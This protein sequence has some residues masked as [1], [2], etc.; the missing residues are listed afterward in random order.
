[1]K[2]KKICVIG[3]GYV[4]LVSS[5]CFA[6]IGHKVICVDN[7]KE[8]IKKLQQNIVPIFE[9]GLKRLIVKNKKTGRLSFT[10]EILEGVKKS[11]IIFIAVH[12]PTD[13]NGQT[14]LCYVES[15][16]QEIAKSMDKYKLIVS[17]STMPVE[18]GKKIKK[19]I[20]NHSPRNIDFDVVSNPE[21]LREGSAVRDFLKPDRI[22]IG[23]EN[24]KA[25][26]IMREIYKPI[27]APIIITN[28]ET[29]EIIKHACNS[30]LATK[31]SFIN[32]IANIC[33]KVGVDVEE[34]AAAM[35]LDK[36][37]G[38]AFLRPGI[39][40]GGSCLPKDLDAFLYISAKNGYDFKLLEAVKN[41][42]RIQKENFVEK[43]KR[44][45]QN[46]KG[47]KLGVLGLAFKPDTDDIRNA[48]SVDII[49]ML[50]KEGAEIKVYDPVAVKKAKEV[51][52]EKITYCQ[53]PYEAALNA[54]ALIILTEWP[55][56]LKID[57]KKIKNLMK[58]P[59]IVDGRNIFIPEKM[60][61]LGFDYSC[62]SRGKKNYGKK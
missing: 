32:A 51:F 42:N 22:V 19:T 40:F 29:A 53:S 8:K 45:I 15:V 36:R 57:L 9:P 55:E 35:G 31:I 4:G 16:A 34:V 12:T 5:A 52:K 37:I 59:I 62:I 13:E 47:K 11:E 61:K 39:G 3:A 60:R 1:M 43:I 20:K 27:K 56:F 46:L 28:I 33:E 2:A 18:T 30:F 10:T 58:K 21:F 48:P 54:D 44:K 23:L 7:D 14:N 24:K 6:E 41:I 49:N 50:V 25:E 26:N 17:K 38:T